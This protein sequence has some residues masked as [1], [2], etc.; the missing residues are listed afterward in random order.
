MMLDASQPV[1]AENSLETRMPCPVRLTGN[2]TGIPARRVQRQLHCQNPTPGSGLLRELPPERGREPTN[3]FRAKN[4]KSR[5]SIVGTCSRVPKLLRV[6]ARRPYDFE[7]IA[8]ANR[9]KWGSL[10]K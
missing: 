7:V 10:D 8:S 1:S 2:K 4:V 9:R 3:G 6:A 5:L